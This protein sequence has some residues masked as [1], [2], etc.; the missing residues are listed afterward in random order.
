[1]VDVEYKGRFGNCL[2]QYAFAR[3]LAERF[4]IPYCMCLE[5]GPL[6]SNDSAM[7]REK[8][9]CFATVHENL[10]GPWQPPALTP[11]H[12]VRFS[13][14]FQRWDFFQGQRERI[15]KFFRM[16]RVTK[17]PE[18]HVGIHLRLADY[19]EI[20]GMVK[21]PSVYFGVLDRLETREIILVTDD[22]SD[23][24]LRAFR[25]RYGNLRIVSEDAKH[26]FE[27]L[28]SMSTLVVGNST[29]SWWAAYLGDASRVFVP[30]DFG[31][32]STSHGLHNL[33]IAF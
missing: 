13:G 1:M 19:H 16:P 20:P 12:H 6:E 21:D 11:D 17:L 31:P 22:P 25:K 27:L 28:M 7:S 3:L 8:P 10:D 5:G 29:F 15:R 2:F 9:D 26:D 33:G 24:Y 18:D 23:P 32:G 4:G 30:R 14:Y